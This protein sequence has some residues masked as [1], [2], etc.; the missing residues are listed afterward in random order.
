MQDFNYHTHTYRCGHTQKDMSDED[1]VKEFIKK[2]FKKIAFT[3]HC[4]EK[5]IIDKRSNMRMEYSQIEEY[6]ESIK[7]LKDKYKD[8]IEIETGFEVEYLPGQEENLL[9][10]KRM[11]DKLVL[12]QHFVY[13]DNNVDLKIFRKDKFKD[14]ELIKYANYI[15][16]AIELS[17]PDI[18]VHPDLYMLNREKF[19]QTE[20]ETAEIICKAAEKYDI[21][22]EINLT[23]AFMYLSNLKD[24]IS[25]PCKGFW[26]VATNYNIKVIYGIDAHYKEQIRLYEDSIEMV[27]KIIGKEI[28]EKLS[29]CNDKLE[30]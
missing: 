28:I 1:F 13:D 5:Q 8:K 19:G 23:E 6:L 27:N 17:I 15:K 4:P 26:E 18:I 12:G 3:D 20:K 9:E 11:T 21:P 10:L 16:K 2:G 30:I 24:K 25:Y 29:F 7:S 14:E 22:L